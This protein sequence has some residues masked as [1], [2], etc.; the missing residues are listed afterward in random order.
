MIAG[1]AQEKGLSRSQAASQL[2]DE[3][4]SNLSIN[5]PLAEKQ[6]SAVQVLHSKAEL[7]AYQRTI[8]GGVYEV[9]LPD[10]AIANMLDWDA[11]LSQQPEAVRKAL[12]SQM[13]SVGLGAW[14]KVPRKDG[15]IEV[16]S[17]DGNGMGYYGQ[18]E[19]DE[20]IKNMN[21]GYMRNA[22]GKEL[23]GGQVYERLSR[24]MAEPMP[25]NGYWNSMGGAPK[26]SQSLRAAGIPGI[27]YLDGSSRAAGA[28]SYNYVTFDDELP[29]ILGTVNPTGKQK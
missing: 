18:A 5:K 27:R 26:V 19:V 25:Q 1:R 8:P 7:P 15:R 21:D 3:A 28:G 13:S 16:F 12:E 29:K 24:S 11:P 2:Y 4:I 20:A 9:E 10:E 14:R 23:T 6:L 22:G 17:P